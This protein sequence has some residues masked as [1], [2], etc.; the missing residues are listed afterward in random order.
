[1]SDHYHYD[2]ASTS[3][4]HRGQY[5]DDRHDHDGDYA[6]KHHRHHDDESAV[7]GLREDLGHAEERIRELADDLRDALN[8][9]HALEDRQPDYAADPGADPDRPETWAFGEPPMTASPDH[10]P[11]GPGVLA[12]Y[13]PMGRHDDPDEPTNREI[14]PEPPGWYDVPNPEEGR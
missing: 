3:H 13:A 12:S 9:I 8:R 4:D 14:E 2:Y 5:A 1:M 6:E 10:E 11:P 7:C